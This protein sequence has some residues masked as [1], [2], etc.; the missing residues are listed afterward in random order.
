MK[1]PYKSGQKAADEAIGMII[2]A[3]GMMDDN[4]EDEKIELAACK[5]AA[6]LILNNVKNQPNIVK[7]ADKLVAYLVN[8]NDMA[9]KINRKWFSAFSIHMEIRHR[10][11]AATQRFDD[12][13]GVEGVFDVGLVALEDA[14]IH[15]MVKTGNYS[16]LRSFVS[17]KPEVLEYI[18]YSVELTDYPHPPHLKALE[19]IMQPNMGCRI[20]IR[21]DNDII[22][23][24]KPYHT[25]GVQS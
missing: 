3:A 24:D 9:M 2:S 23:Y 12:D 13:F 1:Y 18:R 8:K 22:V 5:M 20:I 16:D 10:I 25:K 21:D 19:A 17:R 7:D 15:N 6:S 4:P 14:L 11:L